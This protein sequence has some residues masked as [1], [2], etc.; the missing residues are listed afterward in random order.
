MMRKLFI[1][2]AIGVAGCTSTQE[3]AN[4]MGAELIGRNIDEVFVNYGI[5]GRTMTLHSGDIIHEWSA[6]TAWVGGFKMDCEVR[7]ITASNG[8]IKRLSIFNDTTGAWDTSRCA[9]VF[10][11]VRA[12][13]VGQ[14]KP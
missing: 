1:A 11:E 2:I 8:T 5:P 9:E 14:A 3:V 13:P 7:F 4:T 6:P 12:R 10:R